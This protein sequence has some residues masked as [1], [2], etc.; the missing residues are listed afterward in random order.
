[1]PDLDLC[2]RVADAPWFLDYDARAGKLWLGASKTRV[3]T[4]VGYRKVPGMVLPQ[5]KLELGI[6]VSAYTDQSDVPNPW[7]KVSHFLWERYAQPLYAEGRPSTVPMDRFVEHTYNWAFQ[8]WKHAVWQEFE[9]R[10]KRVGAPA[11]IV[12]VT[13]S[14]NFPGQPTLREFLSIWN[15]AWFSSLRSASGVMNFDGEWNDSRQTLFAELFMDYYRETGDPHLFERGVAALKAGFVMMY[16]PE[17]PRVKGLWEKQYPFFGPEDYGF[18]MENYGHGGV[19]SPEGQGVGTFTIYDWGN[20]AASE[21]RNRIRDHY[22]DVYLDRARKMGFGIDS[23]AVR[24]TADRAVLRDLA[25]VPRDVRVVFDDG[26]SR[27]VRL[28]DTMELEL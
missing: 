17:N 26:S 28:E 1:V 18:T 8:T 27:T 7:D 21:A 3:W 9:I 16:C 24:I 2:G 25:G 19:T 14:P 12:N 11:F 20:G 13:E 4:H 22:G 10:G 6:Y 23:V 5:G 15:Q